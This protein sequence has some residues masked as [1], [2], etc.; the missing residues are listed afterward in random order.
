MT[1]IFTFCIPDTAEYQD[2]VINE[3]LF[4]PLNQGEEYVEFYNR[5]AKIL[6]LSTLELCLISH[7]FPQPPDTVCSVL[8]VNNK[9]IFPGQYV[10]LT[11]SPEKVIDQ[12]Y[13]PEPDHV[14]MAE[15]LIRLTDGGGLLG[16][17]RKDGVFVDLAE[18]HENMHYPLLNYSM[19]VSLEKIHFDL[20]GLV[21]ENWISASF[22]SGFGTPASQNS[23]YSE[24]NNAK[25]EILI[26]PHVFTPNNDG[27]DDILQIEYQLDEP[28]YTANILIFNAEGAQ[29]R[30]LV[31]N[32][33]LGTEGVFYWNGFDD[34]SE[35]MPRGI[36]IVFIEI[37]DLEGHVKRYKETAVLGEAF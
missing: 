21:H 3:I 2:L 6:D 15:N 10:A 35:K 31:S 11:R 5:S 7:V 30:Q 22:A 34:H 14:L 18:Y 28:G 25:S 23:Q 19:G 33:L 13:C 27:H 4:K 16:L 20:P 26:S 36:Y 24:L 37:F 8:S 9:Y 1:L 32:E 29:V 12:Y 17:K